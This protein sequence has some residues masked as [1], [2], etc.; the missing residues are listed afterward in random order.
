[1]KLGFEASLLDAGGA[2]RKGFSTLINNVGKTIALITLLVAAL[3]TF[4]DVNFQSFE[5]KSLTSTVTVMLLAS[6]LMYF[7][8]EDAGEKL[9]EASKEYTESRK[10]YERLRSEIS[11]ERTGDLRLFCYEYSKD[12]LDYRRSNILLRSGLTQ[13]EYEAYKKGA[14]VSGRMKRIFRNI[15]RQKPITLNP[16]VLL[17]YDR[18]TKEKEIRD[19]DG[20]KIP[21]MLLKLLPTTIGTL[22]TVSLVLSAKEDMNAI[23]VIN[24]I[25]KLSALPIIGFRGYSDGYFHV[26]DSMTLWMNTKSRIIE[27]FLSIAKETE[28][29]ES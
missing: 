23:T 24:G 17:E 13:E 21:R 3:V 5:A 8:L 2:V 19:P 14:K 1:M 6:Y 12:E 20:S 26:K 25:I 22:V 29:K 27:Q 7:S 18:K 11:G 28:K 15:D 16:T 4:T 10:R 9:G